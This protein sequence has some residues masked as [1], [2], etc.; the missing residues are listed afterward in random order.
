MSFYKAKFNHFK[1]L[2]LG[3]NLPIFVKM[4]FL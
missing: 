2:I 1:G 4:T 3:L